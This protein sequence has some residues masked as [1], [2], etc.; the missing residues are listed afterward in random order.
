MAKSPTSS[1]DSNTGDAQTKITPEAND[2][3]PNTAKTLETAD[4]TTGTGGTHTVT[5]N[6][7]GPRGF[8][9]A[10]DGTVMIDPGQT[11]SVTLTDDEEKRLGKFK[12][13]T[14]EAVEA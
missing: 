1:N 14:V 9:T 4:S 2:S 11:V 7:E 5:H 8:T 10:A 12:T 6:E 13:F 3:D